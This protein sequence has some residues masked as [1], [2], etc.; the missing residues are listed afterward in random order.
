M[1][2][3]RVLL[4]RYGPARGHRDMVGTVREIEGQDVASRAVKHA[5]DQS[6]PVNRECSSSVSRYVWGAVLTVSVKTSGRP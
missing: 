1:P 2:D 4:S 5:H 6:A 3:L